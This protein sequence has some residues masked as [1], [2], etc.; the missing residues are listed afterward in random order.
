[1]LAAEVQEKEKEGGLK[2][3]DGTKENDKSS[4]N[5]IS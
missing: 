4:V 1:M 2:D 5:A 3:D